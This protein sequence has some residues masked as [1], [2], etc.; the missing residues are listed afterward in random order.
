MENSNP[1][2]VKP[3]NFMT[4]THMR[5]QRFV[6]RISKPW[7]ERFHVMTTKDNPKLH[8]FYKELFGK[9]SHVKH[10][11]M[12]LKDKSKNDY[13][14]GSTYTPFIGDKMSK[15]MRRTVSQEQIN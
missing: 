3:Q 6:T 14:F 9:P 2:D 11:E 15:K 1:E 5:N 13:M 12:L 4:M 10:E 8:L 7:D